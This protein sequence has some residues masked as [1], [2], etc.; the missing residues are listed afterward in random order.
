MNYNIIDVISSS[1]VPAWGNQKKYIAIHYLGVDGQSHE[2][3]ADG[4]GAHYYIY[5]NGTIYQRCSHDAVLWAVGTA[6]Y[7]K[8]IHPY[9]N[10][11]NTISIEMCCHCDG[12]ASSAEDS[13]WWFTTETQEACVWLVQKLMKD[14]NIP[15]DNVLRH[16][17]IVNKTC[18]APYVHNNK[19][20]TSWTWDEFKAKIPE[21]EYKVGTSWENGTCINQIGAYSSLENAKAACQPGYAVYNS[22]GKMVY[23]VKAR[24]TQSTTLSGMTEQKKIKTMAPLYQE[25]EKSTGMLS[26]VGLAQ[27]CLESGYGTTDLAIE[28]NNLHGMKCSLSGNSW[29]GSAWD[30][31]S[32]YTKKTSEQDVNGNTYY[33]T[34]DFRKYECMEDSIAD[35]AA[36]FIG[37]KNGEQLRYPGIS[38]II[39]SKQQVEA[40][41]KGGYATDI[42]YVSKLRSLID[43]WDLTQYDLKR[44]PIFKKG[45][46]YQL[47]MDNYIRTEPSGGYVH[48]ENLSD[49][50]KKK[51]VQLSNKVKLKSGNVVEALEVVVTKDGNEWIRIKSGWLAAIVNDKPRLELYEKE[52]IVDTPVFNSYS[53]KI[54]S[55]D[56]RIRSE[57]GT[58]YAARGYTGIGEFTIIDEAKDS[59]GRTWGLLKAYETK[60]DGWIALWLSCVKKIS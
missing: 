7:Y 19:Y 23:I 47:L 10:N 15:I 60:R 16:I 34:A 49:S 53:V 25:V 48:Y 24:G 57:A 1:R 14:L 13:K 39:D 41:K 50:V 29:S 45:Q 12:N 58:E 31:K 5:W 9:A 33:V 52:I 4:C 22:S 21:C 30:G 6:G 40:I 28:A 51:V 44:E 18:P 36:Y 37:A 11:Y 32:K 43:K 35:R 55:V 59:S 26:S 2:L 20:R 8:Q 42:A 38:N 56:V 54:S 27:F 46:K 3:A 17:D